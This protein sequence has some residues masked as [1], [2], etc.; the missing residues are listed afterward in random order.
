MTVRVTTLK[1]ADAGAYYLDALPTYYLDATGE[2]PGRW[3]GHGAMQLGLTGD[4]DE[5]AFLRVMAGA[6]PD[7]GV[8]LGRAFDDQSV[9][10]FDLTASAPKSVSV[11]WALGDDQ[12]RATVLDA[13]DTAVEAM[14]DWVEQHAHTRYRINGAVAIVDAHGITAALFRQHTSRALDPQLHTHVVLANRVL[15]DD[16]RWLALDARTLKVDQRTLSAL[17]HATL[18][19]ELT[20]TLGVEWEVPQNGIAEI[21]EFDREVLAEF[22]T[23]TDRIA[24]RVEVK[25]ERFETSMGRPPTPR[26][27]WRLEREA[28]TDSRPSKSRVKA[29]EPQALH[30]EWARRTKALWVTPRELLRAVTHTVEPTPLTP[31]VVAKVVTQAI[32]ALEDKQSTWRPAELVREFAAAL[33]ATIG[34]DA[35]PLVTMLDRLAA[36]VIAEHCIDL[37]APIPRGVA[38]R[39][40]GRPVTEPA[41]NRALTTANVLNEERLLLDWAQRRVPSNVPARPVPTPEHLS[42][43]QQAVAAAIAGR[44]PL[45]LV[46]GPA[47]TGKTTAIAPAITHLH[48]EG[49][50]VFGVAPSAVAADVLATETGV[51]ADTLDKLLYEHRGPRPPRHRYDLPAGT[52]II[53][54]EA[55]MVPTPNLAELATLADTQHWRVVLVGD[56]MQFSAVGRGGMYTLLTDTHPAIELDTVHRF[57][58][59]WERDASLALRRSDPDAL[60]LYDTHGRIHTLNEDD[61]I[62]RVIDAWAAARRDGQQVLLMAG[63]NETVTALNHAAQAHLLHTGELRRSRGLDIGDTTLHVGDR[64]VTR[65]NDR[66]LTT[67]RGRSVHNR[68]E[69][70]IDAISRRGDLTISGDSGRAVLPRAYVDEHVEL[71]YAQTSH[72]AQGRTVDHAILLVDGP[73]DTAGIYVP[74]TRG[75]ESNHAYVVTR[76]HET[77]LDVM[78]LALAQQWIDRPAHVRHAELNPEPDD[79]NRL[80]PLTYLEL[81]QTLDRQDRAAQ[82]LFHQ[83]EQL[84]RLPHK[85]HTLTHDHD[86]TVDALER[87]ADDMAR[88]QRVIDAHDRPFHRYRHR[89]ELASAN[90]TLDHAAARGVELDHQRAQLVEQITD[91]RAQ[92]GAVQARQPERDSLQAEIDHTTRALARDLDNRTRLIRGRDEPH[93]ER[94]G[95]RPDNPAHAHLWDHAVAHHDRYRTAYPTP[96]HDHPH[97][98]QLANAARRAHEQLD[99]ALEPDLRLERSRGMG[100]SM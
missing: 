42:G 9:R 47:G 32:G 28:V 12:M 57:T 86:R 68:D 37:S 84:R 76:E 62:T 88:A 3:H 30:A 18:R 64:I 25:L 60:A 89:D 23:R 46:I 27:R 2:P 22:S 69:W 79:L 100:I 73:T 78:E 75:R 5:G 66:Q 17:Y 85:L 80:E 94:F 53:V 24:Q 81:H 63:T 92:L 48:A 83:K 52:T 49:R 58:N 65:Q 74:M 19:S 77:A 61:G 40:D 99:N 55:A 7:T 45:V 96:D 93:L 1:G 41:I 82:E 71:A 15:A 33:P 39:K 26:E 72:A 54:D 13:H 20:R 4:L 6:H 29:Q 16:G 67:S 91:T 14:V 34:H 21:K 10:G 70:T 38:L 97:H 98:F 51:D 87:L 90:N 43:P 8:D 31:E 59:T 50:P 11:L 35:G 36:Q 56:P 95:P 44:E